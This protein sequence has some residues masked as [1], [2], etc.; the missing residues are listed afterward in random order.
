MESNS[1]RLKKSLTGW[2]LSPN[3]LLALIASCLVACEAQPQ[4]KP[5]RSVSQE[6]VSCKPSPSPSLSE[7]ATG[8]RSCCDRQLEGDD[9]PVIL[10][11]IFCTV[12][13]EKTP[14]DDEVC[15]SEL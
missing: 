15:D 6:A 9:R 4:P 11:P 2:R 5:P 7:S 12:K 10:C 13:P 8:P 1:K 14:Q 3:V